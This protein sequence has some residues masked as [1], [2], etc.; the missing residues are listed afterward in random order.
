MLELA[1]GNTQVTIPFSD[2][3]HEIGD[4]AQTLKVFAQNIDER[5]KALGL[6]EQH[7]RELEKS[8]HRLART[9]KELETFAY[10]ASHDLKS[11]LR[12]IAQL[13]SWIDEDLEA[14]EF[15][16]VGKHTLMLRS[17]IHRMKKLLDDMLIFYR[18]GKT[19]GNLVT[20]DI[21]HIATELFEIQNTKPGLRHY[22]RP[23]AP[24]TGATAAGKSPAVA[25]PGRKRFTHRARQS[26]LF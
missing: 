2:H 25:H 16:E 14:K 23:R 17:R 15:A 10:V 7:Q 18:A 26:L 21:A 13:S 24:F 5:D 12:G 8:N 3:P 4:I 19:D 22:P 1:K 20:I 11:P 6:L 9:N